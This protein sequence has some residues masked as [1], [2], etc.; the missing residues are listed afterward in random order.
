MNKK[1]PLSFRLNP[2][3]HEELVDIA[4]NQG[5]SLRQVIEEILLTHLA[6]KTALS[7]T[8]KL[9]LIKDIVL[10]GTMKTGDYASPARER[11]TTPSIR[12]GEATTIRGR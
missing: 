7:P 2:I 10:A 5:I 8:A 11:A 6:T 3:I 12:A 4:K 1:H 9:S